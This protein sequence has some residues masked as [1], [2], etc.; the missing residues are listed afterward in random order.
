ME[1]EQ[2]GQREALVARRLILWTGQAMPWHTDPCWRVPT[3]VRGE[4][5]RIEHLD[6]A[7]EVL[8][9]EVTPAETE[10]SEPS[11]RVHRAVSTGA[12]VYEEVT[13][14]LLVHPDADPQPE[15]DG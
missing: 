14:F 15:T 3:V 1:V 11:S 5:L 9:V 12:C 8:D 6:E 7:C 13:V 2:L 10:W 4:K